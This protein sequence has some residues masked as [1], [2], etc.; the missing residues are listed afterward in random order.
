LQETG[1]G[2][3]P[4][5][6]PEEKLAKFKEVATRRIPKACKAIRLLGN[7]SNRGSYAYEQKY[8]DQMFEALE[9]ALAETKAKFQ[10]D[11]EE[12][13]VRTTLHRSIPKFT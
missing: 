5:A 6:S 11:K 2:K 8:V 3:Q 7:L 1:E 12:K 9:T 10:P 4:A 13:E